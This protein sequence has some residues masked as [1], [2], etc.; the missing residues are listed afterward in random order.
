MDKGG[1]QTNEPKD[2]ENNDYTQDITSK[3]W[4]WRMYVSGKEEGR[5]LISTEDCIDASI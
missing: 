2:K 1:T 3:K 5:G 4:H